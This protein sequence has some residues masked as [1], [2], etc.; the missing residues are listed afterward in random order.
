MP[1]DASEYV[2]KAKNGM[3][4]WGYRPVT[5]ADLTPNQELILVDVYRFAASSIGL[6]PKYAPGCISI[7]LDEEPIKLSNSGNGSKVIYYHCTMPP[8]D[9][10]CFVPL[11]HFIHDAYISDETYAND[12][13]YFIKN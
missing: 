3:L 9:A 12:Y 4:I 5:E 10:Q 7:K 8:W 1:Q 13:R 11:E 6:S 2:T